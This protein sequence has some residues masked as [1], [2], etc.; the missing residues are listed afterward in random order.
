[1]LTIRDD[2]QLR[3]LTGVSDKVLAKLEA[4]FSKVY[5]R[6]YE[7]AYDEGLKKG[8]RQHKAGGGR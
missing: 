5:Q 6:Q 3:S 2:R 7:E 8:T 4:E 1:M